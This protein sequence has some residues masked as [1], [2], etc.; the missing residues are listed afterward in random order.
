MNK[1]FRQLELPLNNIYLI[2]YLQSGNWSLAQFQ[3]FGIQKISH[4]Y[5]NCETVDDPIPGNNMVKTFFIKDRRNN[6]IDCGFDLEYEGEEI[7][8]VSQSKVIDSFNGIMAFTSE[9]E[10]QHNFND[11]LDWWDCNN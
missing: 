1:G 9:E 4:H 3:R 7:N 11:Q 10:A 5:I 6:F 2:L 8:D